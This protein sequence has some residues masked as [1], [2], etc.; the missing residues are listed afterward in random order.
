MR[1]NEHVQIL[2]ESNALLFLILLFCF[3]FAFIILNLISS[4][5]DFLSNPSFSLG[6]ERGYSEVYQ[7]I[8]YF[9]II[10]L[11]IFLSFK[12]SINFF[13]WVIA[14]TY[15]LIDDSLQFHERIGA[16]IGANLN[17][18]PPFGL[19]L[20]DIGEVT[21]TLITG[22]FIFILLVHSFKRGNL[23]FRKVTI[24]LILLILIFMFFGV[25]VDMLHQTITS[26]RELKYFFGII[27]DGG[28]MLSVSFIFWY[29][30]LICFKKEEDNI[31]FYKYVYN[32][33]SCKIKTV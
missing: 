2:R 32:L 4:Y 13:S 22:I 11:L 15:I 17:F 6:T 10:I 19:R 27:E 21:V 28:E 1:K 18:S 23:L 24:D 31:C 7:Y 3:D 12:K 16:R 29:S 9:W 14:F 8:K 30:I 5:T 26:V 20:Q 25:F 33:I